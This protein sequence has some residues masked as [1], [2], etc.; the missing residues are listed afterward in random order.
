MA[1]LEVKDL[2]VNYGA[3][4]AVKGINFTVE[5]GQIVTLIGANG[6]GKTTTMNTI[7]GL[8]KASQGSIKYNGHDITNAQSSTIVKHGITLSPE[9]R[10]VFPRMTVQQNLELGAYTVGKAQ[11]QEGLEQNYELFPVLKERYKQLA[12]TLSGGEQQMLAVARALMSRPRLLM[13]DEPS[14]GLAPLIVKE[15]FDLI[16]RINGLGTTI[17]LVEQNARLALGISDV[18]Y[19]LETGRIVLSDKGSNLASD[20]K[21]I[22]SY[23]GGLED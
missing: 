8:I 2:C 12:G 17:L 23:L 22:A 9:G 13:M 10:Q 3:I 6:A 16:K 21:V 20:P 14:L 11:L 19:V 15:I 5:Q 7:A 18:G 1:M 4:K